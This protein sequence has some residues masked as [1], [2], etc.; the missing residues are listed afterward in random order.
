MA[1][2]KFSFALKWGVVLFG[3]GLVAC[4]PV[5]DD[6][7]GR[8]LDVPPGCT[9]T[10]HAG[11]IDAQ[12]DADLEA[13]RGV[14]HLEGGLVIGAG[15]TDVASLECLTS[16]RRL[17]VV[18][19][20]LAKFRLDGLRQIDDGL[21]VVNNS[22]LV[23]IELP[24]LATV[25][26]TLSVAE[27]PTLEVVA[28][29]ALASVGHLNGA[30]MDFSALPKL[31]ELDFAALPEIPAGLSIGNVGTEQKATLVLKFGSVTKIVGGLR[32][33]GISN[34]RELTGFTALSSVGDLSIL[35]NAELPTCEATTLATQANAPAPAISGN[36]AD[37]CGS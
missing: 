27:G 12:S 13:L 36:L 23:S 15:V 21:D 29:P 33:G 37:N 24:E 34:L 22:A 28:L 10:R 7:V 18:G 26:G 31:R 32:L 14:T 3:C 19:A 16:V 6:L 5:P 1:L 30:S 35:N 17:Q 11:E 9:E 20:T 2:G 8:S 4:K 25:G